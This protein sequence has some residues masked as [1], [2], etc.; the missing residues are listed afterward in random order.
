MEFLFLR[1][2]NNLRLRLKKII[3]KLDLFIKEALFQN[4][5]AE[6]GGAAKRRIKI[7][8]HNSQYR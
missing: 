4:D 5:Q 2:I 1:W 8:F 7:T 3:I 6:L